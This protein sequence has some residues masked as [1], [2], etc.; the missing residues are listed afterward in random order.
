M[1]QFERIAVVT[2]IDN[3]EHQLRGLKTL[4]AASA[5]K[6]GPHQTVKIPQ[7]SVDS[8]HYASEDEEADLALRL[9]EESL[10]LKQDAEAHFAKE[11]QD[12][13]KGN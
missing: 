5:N 13:L 1:D 12:G 8:Q 7:S 11:W 3:I 6:R 9:E 10:R 4:L 2:I